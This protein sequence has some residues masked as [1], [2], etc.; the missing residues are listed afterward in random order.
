MRQPA[1]QAEIQ[2]TV[3]QTFRREMEAQ[4]KRRREQ[5]ANW[6][7][8]REGDGREDGGGD[9]RAEWQ[10]RREEREKQELKKLAE[11]LALNEEQQKRV[12][13]HVTDIRETVQDAFRRMREEGNFNLE[14]IKV[15][16]ED[17]K[18]RNDAVMKDIL[19]AEQ[20]AEYQKRPNPLDGAYNFLTGRGQRGQR[21]GRGG[22]DRDRDQQE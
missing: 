14:E 2:K 10:A 18:N 12:N 11:D 16:V 6:G 13:Q 8:G 19:T 15:T 22:R 17:L 1:V 3:D 21:G 4:E 20:Y 9:R 7:R 5:W